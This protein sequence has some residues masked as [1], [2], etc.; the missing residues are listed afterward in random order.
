[1]VVS[2]QH[3]AIQSRKKTASE[4]LRIHLTHV[5]IVL[6]VICQIY[7]VFLVHGLAFRNL[8]L[9][10]DEFRPL[11]PASF[12]DQHPPKNAER[13]LWLSDVVMRVLSELVILPLTSAQLFQLP[14]RSPS[15]P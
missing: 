2:K 6:H 10:C 15:N 14:G 1:M 13:R 12:G 5:Q 7:T 11:P 9:V 8:V 3:S 4:Y